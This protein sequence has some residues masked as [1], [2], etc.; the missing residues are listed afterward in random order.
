[1]TYCTVLIYFLQDVPDLLQQA[2]AEAELDL[3]QSPAPSHSNPQVVLSPE[4]F[5]I[6]DATESQEVKSDKD[7]IP[8]LTL[9]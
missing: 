7:V 9:K 3:P 2:I 4:K 5:E 6:R 8:F 1:M